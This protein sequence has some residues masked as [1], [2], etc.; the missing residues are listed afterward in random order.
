MYTE[1]RF[2]VNRCLIVTIPTLGN[3][4]FDAIFRVSGVR[5]QVSAKAGRKIQ[6]F[7]NLGIEALFN[8]GFQISD[9]IS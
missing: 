8:C 1:N 2:Y 6:E 4:E 7:R 5:F 9:C 3:D